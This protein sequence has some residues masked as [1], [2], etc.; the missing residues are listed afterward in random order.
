[1]KA[2]KCEPAVASYVHNTPDQPVDGTN[3]VRFAET[4]GSVLS[5]CLGRLGG[6]QGPELQHFD[7]KGE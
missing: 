4:E 3:F 7:A 2:P 6:F 1:M 5:F